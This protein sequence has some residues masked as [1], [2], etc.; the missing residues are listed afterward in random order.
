MKKLSF[1]ALILCLY[2]LSGCTNAT[3]NKAELD[4][5]SKDDNTNKC[6]SMTL[7][8][9]KK[10]I[11]SGNCKDNGAPT[12]NF[13]CNTYSKTWQIEQSKTNDKGNYYCWINTETKEDTVN[14]GR[15]AE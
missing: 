11:A 5:L 4:K 10:I 6:F 14:W 8:E 7:A 2:L 1:F 12:E 15:L 13:Y 3:S 9:A